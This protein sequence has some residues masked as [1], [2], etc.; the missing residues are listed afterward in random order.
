MPGALP[1]QATAVRSGNTSL[2]GV[3][4][5]APDVAEELDVD[6][7]GLAGVQ[8][9]DVRACGIAEIS[10]VGAGALQGQALRTVVAGRQCEHDRWQQIEA[11]FS[12]D[13]FTRRLGCV[14]IGMVGAHMDIFRLAGLA[15]G[16]PVLGGP[17]QHAANGVRIARSVEEVVRSGLGLAACAGWVGEGR[18]VRRRDVGDLVLGEEAGE[19]FGIGG[20][21]TENGGNLVGARPLLVLSD[22]ARHLIA[23]VDRIDVDLGAV[24]AAVLVDPGIGV[25]DALSERSSDVR[26]RARIVGQMP[27]RDRGLRAGC[28]AAEQQR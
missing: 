5:H 7:C 23:V 9:R 25:G 14:R 16:L 11:E 28:R 24:D 12:G 8:D 18:G 21:P 15:P 20:P 10:I 27:Q 17:G 13:R 26:G 19:G 2:G 6:P 3:L 1:P 22:R 4:V